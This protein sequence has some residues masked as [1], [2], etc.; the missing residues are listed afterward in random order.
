MSRITIFKNNDEK[1]VEKYVGIEVYS[2]SEI[3][4]IGGEYKASY[5][6]FIVKEITQD[7]NTLEMR[8]DSES[9][10]FLEGAKDKYTT[11][12]IVKINK[13][14]FE[15]IR[16]ISNVLEI[17][18]NSIHYSGLKDKCSISVQR[19]SIK[20]NVIEKLRRLKLNDIYI[21][22]VTPS[23]KSI[24]LGSHF[25]NN[26]TIIIRN[27]TAEK[28]LQE[29]ISSIL[30]EIN[31]K[32]FPNYYGLQRFG[33][34]RP[35]S[36]KIGKFILEQNHKEAFNEF[37]T[38]I[39]ST[40][41]IKAQLIRK[42]LAVTGDLKKALEE[43]PQSLRYERRMIQSL[44]EKP[45]NYKATINTLPPGL[46]TLLISSFQSWIFNKMISKRK[47][48]GISLFKPHE[49]DRIV[50]FD[51]EL[52]NMTK[53]T[54]LYGGLYD[55]YL[56]EAF[57]LYRAAIIAPLIGYNTDLEDFPFMK[58]IYQ[59]VASEE[60]IKLDF[61]NNEI[62]KKYEF[63]GSYR[64]ITV[65][66]IGLK[67]LEYSK[68]EFYESKMKLKIEFSLVRGCYATMLLREIIKYSR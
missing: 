7:G 10:P 62:L 53:I 35:N 44:I 36:H 67:I 16:N 13:D 61:V 58:D 25:G 55:K 68:D 54:Y 30:D 47:E 27:I 31:L 65:K 49:G 33:S 56:D 42:D 37:I 40:E 19:A 12:N 34:L 48:K 39:Y 59:D 38:A 45:N 66:P 22:N 52:G 43:F 64:P 4:G 23:K 1:E 29:R 21:R 3:K 2:T 18:S 6:D 60:G 26:F 17:P 20:G 46:K 51:D 11:F 5:K 28:N 14:T 8:E 41:S 57:E 9:P 24:K 63:K 32:G 50:I 15:A